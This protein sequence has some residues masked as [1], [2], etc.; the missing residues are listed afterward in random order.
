MNR[1]VLFL[2]LAF[3]ASAACIPPPNTWDYEANDWAFRVSTN[4]GTI[5]GAANRAVTTFF[6]QAKWWGIRPLIGRANLYVGNNTNAMVVCQIRDWWDGTTDT[7]DKLIAF[8]SGDFSEATGLTGD[9]TTKYLIPN[10]AVGFGVRLDAHTVSSNLHFAAYIRTPTNESSVLMGVQAPN[11]FPYWLLY[12]SYGNLTYVQLGQ[13]IDNTPDTNGVGFYMTTRRSSVDAATY[14]NGSVLVTQTT[15]DT[16]LLSS[17]AGNLYV[18]AYNQTFTAGLPLGFTTRTMSFYGV[19]TK[20][21]VAL[22]KPYYDMVQN[23]QITM[24]RAK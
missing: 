7:V 13:A 20:V 21:P 2:W 5:S 4:G 19:G 18:H 24:G 12:P 17:A 14:K 1:L 11:P 9:G 3:S 15:S 10:G 8:A 23:V 16:A 22:A 6:Q